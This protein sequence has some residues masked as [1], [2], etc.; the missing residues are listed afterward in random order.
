[1]I[2][3]RLFISIFS[4]IVACF[5]SPTGFA[6]ESKP[7]NS[8][9]A[10]AQLVTSHNVV[11]PGQNL[12]VALLLKLEPNWHTYWR[13]PGGPGEPATLEWSTR[14]DVKIGE[15]IWPLPKIITTGPI[16]NYGFEDQVLLP[17][18]LQ[19]PVTAMQGEIYKISAQ[20][21]YLV[22][23]D[24]CLPEN[25]QLELSL[26]IGT[27]SKDERWFFDIQNTVSS[28]PIPEDVSGSVKLYDGKLLIEIANS[29][30]DFGEISDPY[31]FP[32]EQDV[33]E[34]S[35]PQNVSRNDT[36]IVFALTPG[37]L[38]EDGIRDVPGVLSYTH[39][40][41][42]GLIRR[43]IVVTA[44]ASQRAASKDETLA[45]T[46]GTLGII[47][48][49]FGA[50]L[51]GLILNLMPCV[52]PV[53][54]LKALGFARAAH[55]D[56]RKITAQGWLYTLGVM[57]SFLVMAILLLFLKAGGSII[58][59]GFQLQ[60]PIFVGGLSLLFFA[61]ALNLLGV[62]EIGGRVQNMGS[63]LTKQDS[64]KGSF[65]TGV[66]AVVVATPCT[67]PFM[68]GA[69]GFAFTQSASH[70]LLI[71]TSLGVGFALPFLALS[72]SPWMLKHLP[73]PGLWM[74]TFKQFLAFPMFA[75]AAWLIWILSIQAGPDGVLRIL[76][77]M[78]LTGLSFWLWKR[79][80]WVS[81]TTIMV[82]LLIGVWTV[83]GLDSIERS[84]KF[85]ISERTLSWSPN[86]VKT[87][88]AQGHPVFVDFTAAWCVTCKVN[89]RTVLHTDKTK[90]LF[91]RTNTKVLV[92]DWT[93]HDDTITE[94]LARH[95]RAGVPLY[96][97]YPAGSTEV[98][99]IILPQILSFNAVETA[100]EVD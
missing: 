53:L 56:A 39:A 84:Q 4:L 87:L 40:T 28:T 27:P 5:I 89:E 81:R 49:I 25:A 80:G 70:T 19:I 3:M 98:E 60:N 48:A 72:Y 73:Q 22:C 15:I 82:C 10:V 59:W 33:I 2:F 90:S 54:S 63:N 92:A 7:D 20:A 12:H 100:L 24:V 35:S 8:G 74:D 17:M 23:Y 78:L 58:A 71:F 62:Y 50:F 97:L 21:S 69:M 95:G 6:A 41:E 1:V 79:Q 29:S 99:P 16:V 52:F 61:I 94:E 43:G 38:F 26:E 42:A 67:A 91:E 96:L 34:A 75:T 86:A 31:F 11:E 76:S 93:S 55:G 13:N 65:F 68:A 18:N 85:A 32:Y 47:G 44:Q 66:L 14:D 36:S 37:Y 64:G 83:Y 30:V 77:A 9:R 88:R 57:A 51:G 46:S 45:A